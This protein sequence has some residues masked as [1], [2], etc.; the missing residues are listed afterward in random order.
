MD[1]WKCIDFKKN[2]FYHIFDYVGQLKGM[3][4]LEKELRAK[5]PFPRI[6][7]HGE[8][9][10]E[11]QLLGNEAQDKTNIPKEYQVPIKN[12]Y[13]DQNN[14]GGVCKADA[15]Y[16]N[17][18]PNLPKVVKKYI[19]Y[20]ESIHKKFNDNSVCVIVG[21]IINLCVY[22]TCFAILY[23]IPIKFFYKLIISSVFSVGSI[24]LIDRNLHYYTEKRADMGAMCALDCHQCVDDVSRMIKPFPEQ[25][26]LSFN[27]MQNIAQEMKNNNRAC[28]EHQ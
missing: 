26:Y 19:M 27:D 11:Y 24:P 3:Y 9:E 1:Y 16:I 8:A 10:K 21:G 2:T 5:I 23:P 14:I 6:I 15:I 4:Y 25:G 17:I 20:H 22:Y 28:E 18:P 13:V 7:D 12:G